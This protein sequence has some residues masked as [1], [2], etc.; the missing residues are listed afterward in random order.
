MRKMRAVP[1]ARKAPPAWEMA[2]PRQFNAGKFNPEEDGVTQE[3]F[4]LKPNTA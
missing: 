3:F 2:A 1:E 4:P